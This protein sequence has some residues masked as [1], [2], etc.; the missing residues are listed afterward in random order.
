MVGAELK[1]WFSGGTATGSTTKRAAAL[2]LLQQAHILL[3]TFS[4][5]YNAFNYVV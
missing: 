3:L 1:K 2:M 4:A 5:M